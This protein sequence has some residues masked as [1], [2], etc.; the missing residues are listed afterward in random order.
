MTQLF[1]VVMM[2]R[3]IAVILLILTVYVT[4]QSVSVDEL[5]YLW[6]NKSGITASTPNIF[7][8]LLFYLTQQ[9]HTNGLLTTQFRT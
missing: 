7:S 1:T 9:F 8:G 4:E 2:V 3:T 5:S 6:A